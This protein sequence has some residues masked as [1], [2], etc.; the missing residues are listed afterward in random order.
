VDA[1]S[2]RVRELPLVFLDLETTG[3]KPEEGDEILEF[4][5]VKTLAGNEIGQM[6]TLVRPSRPIPPAS[7][8]VH[9]ITD[10]FVMGAPAFDQ[11]AQ[12]ILTFIGDAVIVAHNAPFDVSFLVT[13][14]EKLQRKLPDNPVLDSLPLSRS[15]LPGIP[16][17]K[18]DTLK[19]YFDVAAVRAHRALD[20]SRALSKVFAKIVETHFHGIGGGPTLADVIA[21]A[22]GAFR[23][24]DFGEG[25]PFKVPEQRALI[26]WAL[27]EKAD[28]VVSYLAPGRL[29]PEDVRIAP[30]KTLKSPEPCLMAISKP[31][32][33][34]VSLLLRGIRSLKKAG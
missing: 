1:L 21:R 9:G 14:L 6:D 19:K 23:F 7:A 8:K 10:L 34:E 28:L 30:V 17:H 4:G 22:G 27:R 13:Q 18:L 33:T 11:V 5:A 20:D 2:A 16:N 12:D 26:R 3:L 32:G 15:V 29:T 25:L 31:K 24:S